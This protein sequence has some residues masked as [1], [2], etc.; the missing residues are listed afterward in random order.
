MLACP[1]GVPTYEWGSIWPKVNKCDLCADRVTL[2][3]STACAEACPTGATLFGERE[4]LV[5]EA[6]KRLAENPGVYFDHI[7]GLEEVGGT[8]VLYLSPVPFD[9]IGFQ[10]KLQ[11]EP[12]PLLTYRALSKTPHIF[13]L[14][15]TLLGGVYWITHRREAVAREERGKQ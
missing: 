9:K 1:F 11:V 7:L 3:Q 10:S 5:R 4:E 15:S 6:H 14:G 8:C 13:V 2:G 12:L